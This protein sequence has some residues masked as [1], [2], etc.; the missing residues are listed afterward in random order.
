MV[1]NPLSIDQKNGQGPHPLYYYCFFFFFHIP[2]SN[3]IV[4]SDIGTWL[5]VRSVM[6]RS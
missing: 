3:D 5:E 6:G 2:L 4:P 1:V